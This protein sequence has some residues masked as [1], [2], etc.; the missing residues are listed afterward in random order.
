MELKKF[1]EMPEELRDYLESADWFHAY[2]LMCQKQ[3]RPE[4]CAEFIYNAVNAY[5]QN[6]VGIALNQ[7][8]VSL[9]IRAFKEMEKPFSENR[10]QWMQWIA[11][12]NIG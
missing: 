3:L 7:I 4:Q 11:L 8:P 9:Q 5:V 6:H 12:C 10:E 1:E 2:C